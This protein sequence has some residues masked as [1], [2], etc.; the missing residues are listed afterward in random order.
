MNQQDFCAQLG[1]IF[2]H[3]PWVAAAAWHQRPFADFETLH[4]TMVKVVQ[5]AEEAQQ[6]ELI[7]A[8]PDLAGKAAIQGELTEASSHEQAGAGL[9]RLNPEE[10]SRFHALNDAYR[11]KFAFPFI[12]AV[13]GHDKHSILAAFT[14]RLQHDPASEKDQA[15]QQIARIAYFRLQAVLIGESMI[16]HIYYG[17]HNVTTY[18]TYAKALSGLPSIPESGFQGRDNILFAADIDVDVYGNNFLPSYTEG[19]NSMVVATDSMKNFILKQ[20]LHYSGATLE[21]LLH[22][23]GSGF[24]ENYP[25]MESL[26]MTGREQ[27]FSPALVREAD[28]F[29]SSD[30]LFSRGHDDYSSAQLLLGRG[31]Q[32]IDVREHRSGREKFQLIK[33]TGSSFYAFVRDEN[34]TLPERKDRPLFIYLD[35]FWRYADPAVMLAEDTSHYVAAEQVSDLIQQVFHEFNSR[36]IQH[37]V[38]AMGERM[39]ERFPQLDEVAFD[40]Q[41]RLWDTA[42]VSEQ[43]ERLKS[44]CDPRPPYGNLGLVMRRDS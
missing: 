11:Q 4:Q 13:K 19:D 14:Q 10:Y 36:S 30:L 24:L 32:G 37:L 33:V 17:K 16:A 34:T 7:R 41:N 18:R 25:Q 3:A 27:P 29:R 2:E 44:Y 12:L 1:H 21:G 23:I 39:L 26:R 35:V 9:D 40:A 31:A 42:F 15:L 43:D 8:H 6:L 38:H 28:G 20:A 5:Q 22:F